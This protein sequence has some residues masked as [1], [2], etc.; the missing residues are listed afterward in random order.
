MI[1]Q[2]EIG[3]QS[4]PAM[5]K[6]LQT[7][8]LCPGIFLLLAT[9]AVPVA[10]NAAT[11]AELQ[12]LYEQNQ[13]SFVQYTIS[14]QNSQWVAEPYRRSREK[15]VELLN[16]GEASSHIPE[17]VVRQLEEQ[18]RKRVDA[19]LPEVS[20]DELIAEYMEKLAAQVSKTATETMISER[21]DY[22]VSP[23]RIEIH[24]AV[25]EDDPRRQSA[26]H[27]FEPFT[28]GPW[29]KMHREGDGKW[30]AQEAYPFVGGNSPVGWSRRSLPHYG[31]LPVFIPK[32]GLQDFVPSLVDEFFSSVDGAK[33]VHLDSG[34]DIVA[35]PTAA[36]EAMIASIP[37]N[38]GAVPDWVAQWRLVDMSFDELG[39]DRIVLAAEL[40]ERLRKDPVAPPYPWGVPF[41]IVSLTDVVQVEGA[42][43]YPKNVLRSNVGTTPVDPQSGK[44]WT[45]H[46]IGW[47]N[48]YEI[49]ITSIAVNEQMEETAPLVLAD[50][51]AFVDVDTNESRVVGV[52]MAEGISTML[53]DPPPTGRRIAQIITFLAALVIV[54]VLVVRSSRTEKQK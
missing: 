9:L 16:S 4:E 24:T 11:P 28:G 23:G 44:H 45:D 1:G 29:N 19:G 42:G 31:M 8:R 18:A 17:A 27:G 22:F 49:V 37:P 50:G 39:E 3:K 25:S 5:H 40:I 34:S 48:Q 20:R 13:N 30:L 38:R 47:T 53:D 15:L 54:I 46:P 43:W 52:P 2:R 21:R 14:T 12:A 51:T 33:L 7:H 10:A 41:V 35:R 32:S 26:P 6:K 36:D